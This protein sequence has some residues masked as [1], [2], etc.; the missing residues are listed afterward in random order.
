MTDNKLTAQIVG[1]LN[2]TEPLDAAQWEL[3]PMFSY[4]AGNP[5]RIAA[6]GEQRFSV[7][8]MM[9]GK[10]E[11]AV[12]SGLVPHPDPKPT[13]GYQHCECSIEVALSRGPDAIAAEIRRR[14]L[15]EY[16]HKLADALAARLEEVARQATVEASLVAMLEATGSRREP[17]HS[18]RPT[19]FT[20]RSNWHGCQVNHSG[21]V[22]L[23]LDNLP[24][25]LAVEIAKLCEGYGKRP[26]D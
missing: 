22:D 12:I 1:A 16:P 5:A 23:R 21:G 9:R 17:E 2:K 10:T 7:S 13:Y 8:I 26:I 24:V 25:G 18:A 6:K 15:P 20:I 14:L 4:V 11:R 19:A 3:A